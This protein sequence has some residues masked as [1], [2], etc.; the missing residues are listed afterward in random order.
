ME[1]LTLDLDLVIEWVDGFLFDP[2]SAITTRQPDITLSPLFL[3]KIWRPDI[4]IDEIVK[5]KRT[6]LMNKPLKLKFNPS[7]GL[8]SYT[9]RLTVQLS[10]DMLYFYYPADTHRCEFTFRS[11]SYFSKDMELSW[12]GSGVYLQ[13]PYDPN[14]DLQVESIDH[15][16]LPQTFRNL[17]NDTYDGL[18]FTILARRKLSFHLVQTYLPSIFFIVITWLCFLVPARMVEARIGI[19][20]T[21]LL[22]LTSMF[23]SVR[24]STPIVS[25]VK[26]IDTW[27]V[28]C[29]FFVFL[30]LLEFSIFVWLRGRREDAEEKKLQHQRKV[31]KSH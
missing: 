24:E 10:C 6:S 16:K 22:T 17:T 4:Y 15:I 29:I 30:T 13:D 23:A 3:K 8:V 20:M 18:R 1:I 21:T 19:C 31:C 14:F 25:Y 26:A 27:M 2:I 28:F 5:V 12:L 9:T 7:N 11:Y